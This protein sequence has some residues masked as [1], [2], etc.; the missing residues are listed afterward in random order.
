GVAG[1]RVPFHGRSK[2]RIDVG[3]ALG[4][5]AEFEG[6]AGT[7]QLGNAVPV[8]PLLRIGIE[9]RAADHRAPSRGRRLLYPDRSQLP[10]V[11]FDLVVSEIKPMCGRAADIEAAQCRGV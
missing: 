7:P 1:R 6:G 4:D 11:R 5:G 3:L 10:K 2:T 9:M 8:D